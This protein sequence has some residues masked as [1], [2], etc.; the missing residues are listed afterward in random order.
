M[1]RIDTIQDLL[2]EVE[3]FEEE[4]IKLI[5]EKLT[6]SLEEFVGKENI[7][8]NRFEQELIY[9]L[10]KLD[11]TEEKVRLKHHCDYFIETAKEPKAIGKKLGFISQ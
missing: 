11:V 5:R 3:K 7:D 2:I 1:A 9:Y 8:H 4:R 6:S 10:E